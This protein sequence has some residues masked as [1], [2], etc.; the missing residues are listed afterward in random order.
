MNRLANL[1]PPDTALL[2]SAR[3]RQPLFD[4]TLSLIT[5]MF[6]GGHS[7]REIDRERPVNAKQIRG[8]LRF[9]WRAC[10]AQRYR[11][12]PHPN[13]PARIQ[14]AAEW[15][16]EDE[17]ELFGRASHEQDARMIGPGLVDVVVD[18]VNLKTALT[19]NLRDGGPPFGSW[20]KKYERWNWAQHA[21]YA[22]F[23]FIE[24]NANPE[25]AEALCMKLEV[26]G[27]LT[28]LQ[29]QDLKRAMSAWI[30]LG[31]VGSR[32]RR[33]CGSL[34]LKTSQPS[35]FNLTGL[36][37]SVRDVEGA[38][39]PWGVPRLKGAQVLTQQNTNAVRHWQC[40]LDA[41]GCLYRFRQIGHGRNSMGSMSNWPET[42]AIRRKV[43]G[44]YKNGP[45]SSVTF[46]DY[47]P[48]ADL[49]LPIGFEFKDEPAPPKHNLAAAGTDRT[50]MAS[51]I[52][53]KALA[54]SATASTP[55]IVVLNC[56]HVWDEQAPEVKLTPGDITVS[57]APGQV[58][59]A[60]NPLPDLTTTTFKGPM[61]VNGQPFGSAR[62]AF[63]AYT[64]N[65][66]FTEEII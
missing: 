32:T 57:K 59:N 1:E 47:Y 49:G 61:K 48:R 58:D 27:E 39:G 21:S 19:K 28:A 22:L 42:D 30:L 24:G 20:S 56:P 8:H 36:I 44:F 14:K 50:R 33:G 31:G 38:Y 25:F 6:G 29:L 34:W 37:Q 13:D 17:A 45:R 11:D 26:Y 2:N 23:P 4:L 63:R 65:S 43:G 40:W 46:P 55:L 66:G 35:L 60:G 62:E 10:H 18:C 52:I 54:T 15:M 41:V 7:T 5:P 9:W 64:R 3:Q 12:R 51:P 16:F 53:T